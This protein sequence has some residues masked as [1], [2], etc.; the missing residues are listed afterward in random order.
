MKIAVP[1]VG[2]LFCWKP[3]K[4]TVPTSLVGGGLTFDGNYIVR[5]IHHYGNFRQADASSWVTVVEVF[6]S[7]GEWLTDGTIPRLDLM[8]LWSMPNAARD[9]PLSVT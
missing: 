4:L 3:I 2:H 8:G 6:H 5:R 9:C 7:A 1:P